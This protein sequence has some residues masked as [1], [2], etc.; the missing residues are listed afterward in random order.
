MVQ[1]LHIEKAHVLIELLI[2][3]M[4]HALPCLYLEIPDY[5]ALKGDAS[6]D[7]PGVAGIGGKTAASLVTRWGSVEE[8]FNNLDNLKPSEAKKLRGLQDEVA[9]YKDLVTVRLA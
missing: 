9:L 3:S 7:I 8:I 5:K 6:D 4:C 1:V 2:N